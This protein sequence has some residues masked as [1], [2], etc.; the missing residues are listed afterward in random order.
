M[1]AELESYSF[2]EPE[3]IR[4]EQ[5]GRLENETFTIPVGTQPVRP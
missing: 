2:I 1:I 4:N 3:V 5:M